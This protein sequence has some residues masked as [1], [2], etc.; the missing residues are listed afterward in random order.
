MQCVQLFVQIEAAH[1]TVDE[2]GHLD[3]MQFKDVSFSFFLFMFL[4]QSRCERI[5]EKFCQRNQE[6]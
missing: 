3:I 2:L 1:D 5:S 6:M 4:A